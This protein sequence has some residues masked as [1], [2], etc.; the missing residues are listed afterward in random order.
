MLNSGV[1]GGEIFPGE[2][3]FYDKEVHF[4]NDRNRYS[5]GPEFYAKRFEHCRGKSQFIMDATPNY[6]N[7][8]EKVH[9]LY[10]QPGLQDLRKKLKLILILREPISREISFY[11]HEV[12]EY[13]QN[14]DFHAWYGEVARR[15]G[16]VRPA[17]EFLRVRVRPILENPAYPNYSLYANHL[18]EWIK[19]FSRD[20]LLILS[21]D[22]LNEDPSTFKSRIEAFLGGKFDAPME[23]VNT[24]D[25]SKAKTTISCDTERM[26]LEFFEPKNQELYELLKANPGPPMEQ[27]PFPP[28]V[29]SGKCTNELL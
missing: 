8:A 19:Y 29:R 6:F 5:K 10:S 22:E 25:G 14:P 1:C 15:D 11:K 20:Q 28:F 18:K 17:D 16:S 4:F 21:N 23:I 9:K 2:P 27:T 7:E 12:L 3:D 24:S 13:N 26:M